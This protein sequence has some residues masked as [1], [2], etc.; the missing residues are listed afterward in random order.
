[1]QM[2]TPLNPISAVSFSLDKIQSAYVNQHLPTFL[3]ST[4][5][6]RLKKKKGHKICPNFFIAD[7]KAMICDGGKRGK[8]VG[9]RYY[10]G[11]K[12]QRHSL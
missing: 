7:C 9:A 8:E 10:G 6:N 5:K 11:G 1:M 2:T 12:L 3:C 4:D